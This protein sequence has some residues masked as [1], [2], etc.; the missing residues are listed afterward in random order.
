VSV[1]QAYLRNDLKVDVVRRYI[2]SND[3]AGRHWKRPPG[4]ADAFAGYVDV[5]AFLAQGTK[6]NEGLRVFSAAGYHDLPTSYFATEYMLRHSGIDPDRLTIRNYDG[7]HMMY[8]Y[9]PSLQALSD[10]IVA[11]IGAGKK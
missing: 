11:F 7:G 8:L 1:F 4:D 2:G 6:D 10:D 9:Q 5:T 3:E